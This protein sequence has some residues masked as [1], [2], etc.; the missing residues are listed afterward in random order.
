MYIVQKHIF[1]IL[2]VASENVTISRVEYL[3]KL[4]CIYSTIP[5]SCFSFFNLLST[6]S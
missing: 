5:K 2:Y 6:V 3:Q 4:Q 1:Y